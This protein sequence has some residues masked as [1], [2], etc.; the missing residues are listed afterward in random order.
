MICHTSRIAKK[1]NAA[2]SFCALVATLSGWNAAAQEAAAP[3]PAAATDGTAAATELPP[4][5]VGDGPVPAWTLEP[6]APQA[7]AEAAPPAAA[8]ANPSTYP[9]DVRRRIARHERDVANLRR[10][11]E[12]EGPEY[13]EE[14]AESYRNR[15][16]GGVVL[17]AIG[18]VGVVTLIFGSFVIGI[19]DIATSTEAERNDDDGSDYTDGRLGEPHQRVVLW[20]ALIAGVTGISVGVPLLVTGRK[21]KKRQELLRRKEEILAPFDPFAATARLTLFADSEG[22]AAGLR[23]QVT[24]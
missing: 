23:L 20:S 16:A 21:G 1:A 14:A 6:A 24:F 19:Q 22:R 13:S 17:V 12:I 3:A 11:M 7:A 10:A 15:L 4:L 8:N 5:P 2:A 18:A 9:R